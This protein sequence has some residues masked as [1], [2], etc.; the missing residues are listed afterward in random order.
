MLPAVDLL[1]LVVV[2][3]FCALVTFGDGG[4]TE[5]GGGDKS[6]A[7]TGLVLT[8][9]SFDCGPIL[10]VAAVVA[11][12]AVVVVSSEMLTAIEICSVVLDGFNII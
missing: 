6:V 11:V 1:T 10:L 9:V 5:P 12:V 2:S 7:F 4:S 8:T 3:P